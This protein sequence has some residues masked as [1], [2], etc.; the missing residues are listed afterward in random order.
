MTHRVVEGL[1]WAK[2]CE[3]PACIPLTTRHRG[4][5]AMGLRYER[6]LAE[7]IPGAMPGQWWEFEDANGHGWCQTD[8]IV[9]LGLRGLVIVEVKLTWTPVAHSQLGRLYMPVVARALDRPV[10]GV[11]A[12]KVLRRDM[13][14]LKPYPTLREALLGRGVWHWIGGTAM[15]A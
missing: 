10:M 8:I 15:A 12:C 14:A 11:V 1:R 9:D 4:A 7:A 6:A 5:K 13:G 2:S 3:R